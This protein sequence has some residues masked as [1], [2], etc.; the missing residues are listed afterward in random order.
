MPFRY[1]CSLE[2]HKP[3]SLTDLF[4]TKS[5]V[6]WCSVARQVSQS[7]N[8]V[9]WDSFLC[10]SIYLA[11]IRALKAAVHWSFIFVSLQQEL[12]KLEDC[13]FSSFVIFIPMSN[14]QSR[15]TQS[16]AKSDKAVLVSACACV[17]LHA[18]KKAQKLN[19]NWKKTQIYAPCLSLGECMNELCYWLSTQ[20]FFTGLYLRGFLEEILLFCFIV[21]VIPLLFV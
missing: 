3:L 2:Y 11:A 16:S 9:S 15:N 17:I 20:L 19:Q 13:L 7:T 18:L 4:R 6:R 10:F 14:P 1:N 5:C 8:W 12:Q 21:C